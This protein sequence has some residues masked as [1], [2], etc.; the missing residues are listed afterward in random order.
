MI[1]PDGK[2][3]I[4]AGVDYI[5]SL[6]EM[7][8]MM[9]QTGLLLKEVYSIPGRKKFTLGEPRAYL[10]AEKKKVVA[11]LKRK[12]KDASELYLATDEDREGEAI[13]WHVLQIL[14]PKIPVKRMVFHEITKEAIQ[15]AISNARELDTQL[16]QKP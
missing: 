15:A 3:E 7:E 9:N 5:Y 2:S 11:E 8:K 13:A 6:N 1:T 10:V 14:K 16:E 4:K 12:L